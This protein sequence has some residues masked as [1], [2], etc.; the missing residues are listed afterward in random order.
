M[1]LGM[2]MKKITITLDEDQVARIR[3][4]VDSGQASSVSG[5][6]QHAVGVS[7]D[8]VAGWGAMLAEALERTG[9]CSP[10]LPRQVLRSPSRQVRWLRRFADLNGKPASPG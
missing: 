1:V 9:C 2:A 8:D 5:F 7:L 10:E 3:S 6:V 4:L